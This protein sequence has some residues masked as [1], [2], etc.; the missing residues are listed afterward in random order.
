MMNGIALL[1]LLTA[2]V[3]PLGFALLLGLLALLLRRRGLMLFA[4]L[5]LWF[6]S[7]P[8]AATQLAYSLE[9]RY[10]LM[11]AGDLPQ[12]DVILVLG[13]ALFPGTPNW[14]PEHNLNASADRILFAEKLLRLKK[15]PLLLYSGGP[16]TAD[17]RSEAKAAREL[18]QEAG[19]D[20]S[21][22]LLET[23]SRTTRENAEFSLPML[24]GLKARKVLL[25]TSVWHMQRAMKTFEDAERALNLDIALIPAACDPVELSEVPLDFMQFTPNTD[26]LDVSRK[27]FKEWLGLLFARTTLP[28]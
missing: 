4:L 20:T 5:W 3:T 1:K 17:G 6:W 22:V 28:R 25:V 13:G 18:M 21:T 27:M 10:P 16:T 24:Q 15:A 23:N 9:H 26:A 8:W 2:L 7:M 19:L 12:A 11:A 14:H